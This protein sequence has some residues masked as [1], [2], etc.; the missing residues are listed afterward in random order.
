MFGSSIKTIKDEVAVTY[1]Q[2][3][4]QK[5]E[6]YKLSTKQSNRFRKPCRIQKT[7]K[8][9]LSIISK[10]NT[11]RPT[12]G[13]RVFASWVGFRGDSPE[14]EAWRRRLQ[15]ANKVTGANDD[16]DLSGNK[17][18]GGGA[19]GTYRPNFASVGLPVRR[20]NRVDPG[21]RSDAGFEFDL[22][23]LRTRERGRRA[24][25]LRPRGPLRDR[26]RPG[27]ARRRVGP[28]LT[29]RVKTPIFNGLVASRLTSRLAD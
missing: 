20:P 7:S 14:A 19:V 29:R 26:G 22:G 5:R 2:N 3:R 15:T 18:F 9:R 13:A 12:L 25:G 4:R 23:E 11:N 16:G 1:E 27:V 21:F 17:R 8:A 28:S 6:I 10:A 24:R